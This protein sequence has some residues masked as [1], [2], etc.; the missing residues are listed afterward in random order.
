MAMVES[1]LSQPAVPVCSICIANYNGL[2]I[3]VECI[4]SVL[5]QDCEF[6]VEIIVH[7]DASTDG[8][9]ELIRT[10]F[11]QVKLIES[12]EN[13]GF[14]ISNNRMG[15]IATGEYLLLLN[16][17]ATLMAGALETLLN[18]ATALGKP[19]ILTLPQY[20]A[21]S[22]ELIDVGCY[23]DPFLNPVPN[24]DFSKTNVGM[25]IGACLWIPRE[26]WIDLGGFPEWFDSLAEDMYLCCVARLAGHPV[27]AVP[28]SGYRHHVGYSFGG[29]KPS[30]GRL[31]L[32]FSRRSLSERNKS[33]VMIA[34]YPAS[35]LAVIFP[36]HILMLALEGTALALLKLNLDI[37][38]K[39]YFRSIADLWRFRH[40][41]LSAR[42]YNK[43]HYKAGK[44]KF[45]K[46]FTSLPHKF[47]LL[48]RFG[49]PK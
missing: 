43:V 13:V 31:K 26:L 39:V 47:V 11:P 34:T 23:L 41:L 29:G 40:K 46:P 19:A 17:D 30:G 5:Y 22:Q 1:T 38:S 45:F 42:A 35:A 7:D 48:T 15:A 32:I 4:E 49:L 36:L 27:E 28:Q 20:D 21:E 9:A 24:L 33:F 18:R 16:N 44:S 12:T 8:S 10:R 6:P 14:C 25:V 3:I 2:D 37:F